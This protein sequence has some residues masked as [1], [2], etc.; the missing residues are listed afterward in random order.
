MPAFWFL[1][2]SEKQEFA[3]F[4]LYA[5]T[6]LTAISYATSLA[7][8]SPLTGL[9]SASVPGLVYS[10]LGSSRHLNVG[11]WVSSIPFFPWYLSCLILYFFYLAGPAAA[12]ALLVREAVN[13]IL[14]HPHDDNID[15]S[16][17]EF[18]TSDPERVAVAVATIIILQAS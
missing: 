2:V 7:R 13:D 16:F 4:E 8:L 15:N 18:I 10:V 12:L 17:M 14:S 11:E 9:F 1:N 3:N 5:E 6:D